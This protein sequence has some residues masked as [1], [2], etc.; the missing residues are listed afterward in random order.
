MLIAHQGLAQLALMENRVKSNDKL[1][2]ADVFY[3][4]VYQE[5]EKEPEPKTPVVEV[6]QVVKKVKPP[7]Q[8]QTSDEIAYLKGIGSFAPEYIRAN[9][10]SQVELLT[11]Y[12]QAAE[13]RTNWGVMNKADVIQAAYTERERCM[14]LAV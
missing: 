7:A 9:N 14:A 11:R 3:M 1:D 12:I 8:R 10:L 2:P 5:E 6:T 13:L 4:E